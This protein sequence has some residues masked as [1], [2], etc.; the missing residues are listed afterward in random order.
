MMNATK[1]QPQGMFTSSTTEKGEHVT[2]A[3][4]E[5]E[6]DHH[7]KNDVETAPAALQKERSSINEKHMDG[8]PAAV[9]A[10]S[11]EASFLPVG[12]NVMSLVA[13]IVVLH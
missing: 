2:M 7:D 12:I 8:R 10:V 3:P 6:V 1:S 11:S 4:H 5:G 13:V 9:M